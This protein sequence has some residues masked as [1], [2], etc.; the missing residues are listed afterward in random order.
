MYRIAIVMATCKGSAHL[1][2]AQRVPEVLAEVPQPRA[3]LPRQP[4]EVAAGHQRAQ[5][6]VAAAPARWLVRVGEGGEGQVAGGLQR[7]A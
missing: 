6:A 2:L 7:R 4:P 3:G 1:R 5:H